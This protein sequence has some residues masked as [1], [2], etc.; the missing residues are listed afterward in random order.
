MDTVGEPGARPQHIDGGRREQGLQLEL[1]EANIARLPHL[2]GAHCLSHR[3]FDSGAL[4][5]L[6]P[7]CGRFLAFARCHESGVGRFIWA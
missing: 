4:G 7:K 3:P 5:I 6:L 1:F 2:T